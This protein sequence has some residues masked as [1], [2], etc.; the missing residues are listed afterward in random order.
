MDNDIQLIQRI[1]NHDSDALAQLYERHAAQ[2]F[3]VAIRILKTC[4]D[5]EDL[6]HDVFLEIWNKAKDFDPTRG[7]VR[8]WILIRLRSRAIDRLRIHANTQKF[9]TTVD[10]NECEFIQTDPAPDLLVEWKDARRAVESLSESQSQVIMLSYFEGLTCNEIADL[11]QIPIGT[12]KSRLSAA[13]KHLR[14]V[15]EQNVEN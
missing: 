12:V 10:Y 7:K 15:L 6:V 8:N 4:K 13:I 2:M 9:F 3:S 11:C 5:A 14:R 1:A